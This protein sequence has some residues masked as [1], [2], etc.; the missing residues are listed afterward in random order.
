[1]KILVTGASG[2]IG[3]HFIKHVMEKT[4]HSVVAFVR[5]SNQRNM[6]RLSVPSEAVDRVRTV[7]GDLLNDISGLTEGCDVVVN[8][9]A[10]TF[11]DHSIRDPW[12]F[13]EANIVGTHRLLEDARRN[14][15]RQ[16][17][18]VSTDE[19]YGAILEGAYHEDAR[20]N[21]TNP[22]AASKAGADALVIS[23]AHTFGMWTAI[24][25]TENNAGPYQHPQKVFPAFV[26]KALDG[27]KLPI[28]GD[29]KHRRQWLYVT[30]HC[31]AIL[32]LLESDQESGQV[33]H[34]AGSQELENIELARRILAS[35]DR[36]DVAF[37]LKGCPFEQRVSFLDDHDARPGHDRRYALHC[38]KMKALGWKPE[39]S[40]DVLIETTTAWY[41]ANQ[42]W[43]Q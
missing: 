20:I 23:Y 7:F 13:I 18:Q 17:V 2:F 10:K 30:D 24:T 31:S 33:F 26:K 35:M 37:P 15:V 32:K 16:F 29:G 3:S 36:S 27:K 40:L 43:L 22:Y 12:P 39:V 41:L 6:S 14:K 8:F 28:Y 25:R 4:N 9:A 42:W 1:M 34:V 11:V 19:V 21:P 5:N 38:D